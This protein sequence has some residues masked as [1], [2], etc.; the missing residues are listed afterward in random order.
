MKFAICQE[1]FENWDWERQC[2]FSAEVGYTGL[3]VAPFTLAPRITDVSAEQRRSLRQT[4]ERHGVQV[5][6]LHWLLAK[7]EGILCAIESAHAFA[8]AL[9]W[10][11][12]QARDDLTVIVSCSGRGDKDVDTAAAWF[13]VVSDEEIVESAVAAVTEGAA[14]SAGSGW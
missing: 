13:D 3:E 5:I 2:A 7:T 4:A 8:G 11:R 12:E 6:G 9:Q 1:L 14:E 10:V